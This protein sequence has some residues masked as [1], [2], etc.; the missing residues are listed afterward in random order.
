ML[1]NKVGIK[2]MITDNGLV[3]LIPSVACRDP[4]CSSEYGI[5]WIRK[6][7]QR[8]RDPK[9]RD[10]RILHYFQRWV[11]GLGLVECDDWVRRDHAPLFHSSYP[12][13]NQQKHCISFIWGTIKFCFTS[14]TLGHG[15][16]RSPWHASDTVPSGRCETFC[17]VG[18]TH[19]KAQSS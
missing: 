14:L 4:C 1:R 8:S 3:S 16:Q 11:G 15:L 12:R 13:C 19:A 17:R 2:K 18:H 7:R 5:Q 6:C 10:E 9:R